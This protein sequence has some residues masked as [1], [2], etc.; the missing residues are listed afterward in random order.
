MEL[1]TMGKGGDTEDEDGGQ[2]GDS[3]G[4]FTGLKR[5]KVKQGKGQCNGYC[6]QYGQWGHMAK[7]CLVKGKGKQ[8]MGRESGR[9]QG[10]WKKQNFSIKSLI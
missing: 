5:G 2:G 3:S 7:S 10:E 9:A 4:D 6:H 1:E 8:E